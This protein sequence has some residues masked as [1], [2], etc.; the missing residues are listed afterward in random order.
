MRLKAKKMKSSCKDEQ[1]GTN[2][3]DSEDPEDESQHSAAGK[4]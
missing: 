3:S 2:K 4:F 1:G